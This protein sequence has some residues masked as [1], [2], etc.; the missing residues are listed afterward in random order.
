MGVTSFHLDGGCRHVFLF[1]E[2]FIIFTLVS[3]SPGPFVFASSKLFV[4][5]QFVFFFLGFQFARFLVVC[6]HVCVVDFTVCLGFFLWL[7][8]LHGYLTTYR[9]YFGPFI[10]SKARFRP[11]IQF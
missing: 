3:S 5:I 7:G 6:L 10:C 4:L 1:E 2:S 11:L 9:S 8:L